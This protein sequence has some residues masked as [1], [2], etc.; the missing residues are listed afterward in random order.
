M[1]SRSTQMRSWREDHTELHLGI[2]HC[3]AGSLRCGKSCYLS[4]LDR[5]H[6]IEMVIHFAAEDEKWLQF[7]T[8]DLQSHGHTDEVLKTLLYSFKLRVYVYPQHIVSHQVRIHRSCE[9][10]RFHEASGA[11]FLDQR[12][13]CE[14]PRGSAFRQLLGHLPLFR[15]PACCQRS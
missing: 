4:A 12:S 3:L 13:W 14:P 8:N 6:R 7:S 2:A 11:R 9:F 10:P 5:L 15:H 1:R